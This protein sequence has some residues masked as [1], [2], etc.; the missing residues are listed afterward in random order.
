[1]TPFHNGIDCSV[2]NQNL[3]A[4]RVGREDDSRH[5]RPGRRIGRQENAALTDRTSF[6]VAARYARAAG[7]GLVY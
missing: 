4:S 6:S 1:M 2:L 5:Q 7:Q 3:A